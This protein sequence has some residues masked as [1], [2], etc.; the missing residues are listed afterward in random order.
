MA[1]GG[2]RP[3][4]GRPPGAQNKKTVEQAEAVA[5]S[6]LTPLDYMLS[7]LRDNNQTQEARMD[8]AKASAPY[9]HARLNAIDA[10]IRGELTYEERLRRLAGD[11]G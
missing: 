8:A 3:G 1:Q 2:A 6:G 10:D 9:S 5:A 7:I 11:G 4:A